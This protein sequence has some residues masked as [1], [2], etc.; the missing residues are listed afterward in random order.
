M[1]G[2]KRRLYWDSLC[3]IALYN[4]EATTDHAVLSALSD[5]YADMVA[6]RIQIVTSV[7]FR[8]EVLLETP[9]QSE[10]LRQSLLGCKSFEFLLKTQQ[11]EDFAMDLQL[12]AQNN[13]KRIKLADAFHL[14]TAILSRSEALWTTDRRMLRFASSGLFPEISI[15]QP[16]IEQPRLW[17]E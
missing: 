5:T 13:A 7:I 6:G 1:R 17:V 11:V 8:H 14:A 12:R 4:K 16:S 9:A 15:V 10:G 2:N 3:F